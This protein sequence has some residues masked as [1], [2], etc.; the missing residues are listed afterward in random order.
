VHGYWDVDLQILCNTA[1]ED[2]PMLIEQLTA[3]LTQLRQSA[4]RQNDVD[5]QP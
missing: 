3:L 1:S 5:D 2:L 4:E